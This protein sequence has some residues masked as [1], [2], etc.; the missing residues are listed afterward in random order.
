M[1]IIFGILFLL[2]GYDDP[3][4]AKA[5]HDDYKNAISIYK[6]FSD[7]VFSQQY[8]NRIE[9]TDKKN[10]QTKNF[11]TLSPIERHTFILVFSQQVS[12]EATKL[13]LAWKQE[14]KN[15]S[16]SKYES[17]NSS[18]AKKEDVV[19]YSKELL[20]I[21]I[22]FS[23]QCD[24]FVRKMLADFKDDITDDEKKI[25]YKKLEDMKKSIANEEKE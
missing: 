11:L 6:K 15:F 9:I 25:I 7:S 16:D 14:I 10:N 21:R 12:Q 1:K 20:E 2:L 23:K 17:E 19:K 5:T 18:V 8:W 4:K 24:S 22:A 13:Q 3:I